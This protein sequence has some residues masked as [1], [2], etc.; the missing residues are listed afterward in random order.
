MGCRFVSPNYACNL[1][2]ILR[3]DWPMKSTFTRNLVIFY[4]KNDA[5][6]I[7]PV[8]NSQNHVEFQSSEIR[9]IF[10]FDWSVGA[11]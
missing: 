9:R 1:S 11:P 4:S 3:V 2:K 8:S 5:F 10:L 6:Y 7:L